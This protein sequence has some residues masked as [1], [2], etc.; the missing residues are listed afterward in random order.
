ME[1]QRSSLPLGWCVHLKAK[2]QK[3]HKRGQKDTEEQQKGA[4]LTNRGELLSVGMSEM[5]FNS[6]LA[7]GACTGLAAWVISIHWSPA[8]CSEAKLWPSWGAASQAAAAWGAPGHCCHPASPSSCADPQRGI[9]L[10][11]CW[12]H[13]AP[14]LKMDRITEKG[15]LKIQARWTCWKDSFFVWS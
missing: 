7:C 2:F 5:P 13:N 11:K 9:P 12:L 6:K 15:E 8:C 14:S 4:E 10:G 1:G 3:S